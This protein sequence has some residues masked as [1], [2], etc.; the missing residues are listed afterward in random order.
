MVYHF[1]GVSKL[2]Y[3]IRLL[4]NYYWSFITLLKKL[5]N[6]GNTMKSSSTASSSS[7]TLTP[8]SKSLQ[9]STTTSSSGGTVTSLLR[10]FSNHIIKRMDDNVQDSKL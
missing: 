4:N 10:Y 5:V 8:F 7:L 6:V 2:L 1:L 9:I 3:T